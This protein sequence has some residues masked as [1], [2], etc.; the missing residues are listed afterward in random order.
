MEWLS[1]TKF[2]YPLS[3][4]KSADVEGNKLK[5]CLLESSEPFMILPVMAQLENVLIFFIPLPVLLPFVGRVVGA[6][7]SVHLNLPL[8]LNY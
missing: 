4:L 6:I 2:T 8:P 5:Y 3:E 7:L 1:Q